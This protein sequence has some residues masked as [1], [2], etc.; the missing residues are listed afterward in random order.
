V[1]VGEQPRQPLRER[2][3]PEQRPFRERC[4][5]HSARAGEGNAFE[6]GL[7]QSGGG[8]LLARACV[9]R[10][11]EPE[12]RRASHG[13]REL[14]RILARE[15]EQDLGGCRQRVEPSL[16]LGRARERRVPDVVRWIARRRQQ[17]ALEPHVEPIVHSS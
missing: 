4:R 12:L 5:V 3:D 14:R 7:C 8:E 2:E 15:A 1:L 17:V 16:L 9:G 13:E 6:L 10:L 11:D